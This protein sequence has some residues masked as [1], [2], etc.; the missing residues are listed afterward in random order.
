MSEKHV[1]VRKLDSLEALGG[2]TDIC[3]DK[4]GTLTQGKMVARAMYVVQQGTYI[5]GETSDPA[6]PTIGT[7]GF[8]PLSPSAQDSAKDEGTMALPIEASAKSHTEGNE[9]LEMMLRIASL[10]NLA[11][12]VHKD[13]VWSARGD[14]TECAIQV[15]VSKFDRSRESLT[16]GPAADW[17][18]LL[19]SLCDLSTAAD[20]LISW[21]YSYHG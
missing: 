11:T 16:E 5:M 8:T 7:L 20:D 19:W 12:V 14:P 1:I 13:G 4:T 15:L 3:S 21:L 17:G 10:C 6:N 2:T 18:E 9:T